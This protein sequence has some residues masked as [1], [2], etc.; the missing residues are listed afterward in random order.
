MSEA[1]VTFVTLKVTLPV[2]TRRATTW[3]LYTLELALTT[4]SDPWKGRDRTAAA[5]E[6]ARLPFPSRVPPAVHTVSVCFDVK[7]G[8]TITTDD[9][10]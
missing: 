2:K 9:R 8:C 3:D 10:A 6:S 1:E 5:S 7:Y 4:H